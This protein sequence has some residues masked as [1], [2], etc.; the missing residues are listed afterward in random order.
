M[1]L[2]ASDYN[3]EYYKSGYPLHRWYRV[4]ADNPN[5]TGEYFK[6]R[7]K[8]LFD[9][10]N[11]AGK[12]VLDIG[13]GFGFTVADL[14]E[15]GANAYGIDFSEYAVSVANSPYVTLQDA[16]SFV[17]TLK[18]G[19]YDL[20]IMCEFLECLTDTEITQFVKDVGKKAKQYF[21]LERRDFSETV[22]DLYTVKTLTEWQTLFPNIQIVMREE[23]DT[24]QQQ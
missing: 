6:D 16:R 22:A 23:E 8:K 24:W 1:A 21:V 18:V 9:T 17:K 19:E 4:C 7:A 12:K 11:L 2:L 20:I 10:Y 3:E 15:M 5:C 14:R 13:C